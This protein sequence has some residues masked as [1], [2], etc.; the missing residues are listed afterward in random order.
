MSKFYVTTSI[1]YVNAQPHVGFAMELTI[2]D[3]LA[4][5]HRA[6]GD[7]VLF[8]TGTDE[9]GGKNAEAA[10]ALGLTP[11]RHVD[12]LSQN[13]K[14]LCTVLDISNDRFLRTT[15]KQHIAG[16]QVIWKRL[17]DYIYKSTYTG[18]YDQREEE[19]ITIEMARELKEHN[20]ERF[21]RL[22]EVEEENYFFKLS[23]FNDEI[24]KR[25]EDNSFRIVPSGY[26]Q[27]ILQLLDKGLEDIS[28]SRPKS[29]LSWGVPVPG[30][31]D[32]IMYVWFD[33]LMNYITVLAYPEAA[34][35]RKFW[36]AD[37]QVIGKDITR[38]HA[39][40]WPAM[41]LGLNMDLPQSLYVHGFVTIDGEKMSKSVGNVVSPLE[42]ISAYGSD[43][44]RY[45]FLRHI[46]SY[47][48][49]DFSW[50]KIEEAYNGELGNELGNLVQ[51]LAGMVN[52]FQD[53]VLGNVSPAEHD[54]GPYDE[55]LEEFR[56]D[57]ALDYVFSLIKGQ[58]R[59]I[60]EQKPWEIAKTDSGHVQEILA[61]VAGSVLQIAD[62]LE[63][64]LPKTSTKIKDI[65]ATGVVKN[66]DGQL[67]PKIEI[68]TAKKDQA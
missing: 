19:F 58:N 39:A 55:A 48:D 16:A 38:F 51:R 35:L 65:F 57:K 68:H 33:A 52:Q 2:A 1:P 60:D 31:P 10:A 49:G 41:L 28:I 56:F 12:N 24:K 47:G 66:Y 3:V 21:A 34:D 15:D 20:P 46:P 40:I 62:L 59:Y 30:D 32:H 17:K 13:Y 8:S 61:Y 22:Q 54:R 14:D 18:M 6:K 43:A 36:P 42:I 27:E 67:F 25:I 29:K 37:V 5:Y 44:M 45:Y 53:G 9:H 63:P 7:E 26:R 4:R 23:A 64:F 50:E 11:K